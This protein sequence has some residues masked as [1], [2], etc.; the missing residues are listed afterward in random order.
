VT[1]P[2]PTTPPPPPTITLPP[3]VKHSRDSY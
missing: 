3:E 1:D 2:A